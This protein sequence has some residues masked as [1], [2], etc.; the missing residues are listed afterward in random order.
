M[1]NANHFAHRFA[2]PT[3]ETACSLPDFTTLCQL[4]GVFELEET[5]SDGT[6]TVFAPT[7]DAFAAV[8]DVVAGLDPAVILDVLLFHAVP[9]QVIMSSDFVCD[10]FITMANGQDSQTLCDEEAGSI[11]QVGEGNSPDAYPQVDPADIPVCNGVLHV[12][13]NILIPGGVL[14]PDSPGIQSPDGPTSAPGTVVLVEVAIEF[15][16]FA[17]ETGW[18]ITNSTGG[19][20]MM[21]PIGS[22]PPLTETATEEVE[23]LAGSNYTFTIFDL[24]GD[25]LSNPE[26]GSYSVS[27]G[28]GEDVIILVS[29]G[30]NFGRQESTNFTVF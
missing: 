5:L 25:G 13:D 16:G 6:W 9:D 4:L 11:F 19:T 27:Q 15:D 30:S 1:F 22:Y 21:V 20:V 29:G 10:G 14:P 28:E 8:S 3:A 23:L 26:D 17:P 18:E 7:N 2:L 24:F 12:V